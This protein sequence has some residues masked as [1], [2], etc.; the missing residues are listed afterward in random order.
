[1]LNAPLEPFYEDVIQRSA[2]LVHTD[3]DLM[4]LEHTNELSTGELHALIAVEDFRHA[5]LSE[6]HFKAIHAKTAFHR[7]RQQQSQSLPRIPV[8]DG[9]QV[10]ESF[11][12]SATGDVR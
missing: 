3:A 7:I 4:L 6:R 12:K 11:W 5:K 10:H 9:R 8:D 1:M 2:A